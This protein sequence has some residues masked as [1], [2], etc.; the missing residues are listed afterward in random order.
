MDRIAADQNPVMVTPQPGEAIFSS[1]RLAMRRQINC[2]IDFIQD[3]TQA[4]VK[5][6]WLAEIH[7][8]GRFSM[9]SSVNDTPIAKGV[10]IDGRHTGGRQIFDKR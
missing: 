2:H 6:Q 8:R 3:Y 4:C 1:G 9:I 7:Q 10:D 5:K